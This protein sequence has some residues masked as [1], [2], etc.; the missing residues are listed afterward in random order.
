MLLSMNEKPLIE[1]KN[2]VKRYVI[3]EKEV[4]ILHGIS[5]EVYS[6]DMVAI[7]G[8]SGSGKST[9]M[10][11]IGMLDNAN[12]GQ[13]LLDG[14]D[15]SHLSDDDMAEI[16]NL[17]IGF[18]FQQFYLLP[19]LTAEQNVALPLTYRNTPK[20]EIKERVATMLDRVGMGDR[21]HHRPS[22][23]SGGQ[24]QRV[25]IARALV[26]NPKVILADEPTG[27]LDSKTSDEVMNLFLELNQKEKRTIIIVTH[28]PDVGDACKRK[29]VVSDGNITSDGV[30]V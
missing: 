28:D 24:Q 9:T 19:K 13:Y 3:A 21:S 5:L 29:I 20:H 14:K 12:E 11:I 8:S 6:G 27:A 25:A 7:M 30:N 23:L 18:V 2:I 15:V 4:T 16:R 1:L 26:G 22:E 17:T 10:N